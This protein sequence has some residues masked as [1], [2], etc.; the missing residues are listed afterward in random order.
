MYPQL[1]ELDVTRSYGM[2][3]GQNPSDQTAAPGAQMTYQWYA[4]HIGLDIGPGKGGKTEGTLVDTAIEFGGFGIMPTDQIKQGQKG[5]YGAGAVYPAG[6]SWTVDSGGTTSATIT[7]GTSTF[8]DFT[9]IAAKG[10][11]IYYADTY[12]VENILGEGEFGVAE[13]AQDMGGMAMNYGNEAMWLRYGR[14][15]TVAAGNAK[16][17][18][19]GAAVCLGG[20]GSAEAEKAYH[21][22]LVGEDPQTAVFTATPGQEYRMHVLMPFGPG[23]G[24]TFDLH[25]HIWQRDPY[26]CKSDSDLGIVGKCNTGNGLPGDG[27]VGSQDLGINPIGFWLGGIESWFPGQHYEIFIPSAGGTNSV[28]GDYLFRDH[29]GLGN[30]G[31]LWGIVRVKEAE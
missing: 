8:R 7:A 15:P 3:V 11:S 20:I 17:N 10:A 5:L 2:N 28:P 23:R 30:T 19:E 9:N 25:G 22:S 18:G 27:S 4:G 16:C 13:D 21:N 26:L 29:M 31:G 12:P 1:L 6:S 24:S 14:N